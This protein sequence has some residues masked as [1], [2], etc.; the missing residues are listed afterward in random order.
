MGLGT[1][2]AGSSKVYLNMYNNELVLEYTSREDLERRLDSLGIEK[3]YYEERIQVRK[4]T[5]GKN[6]GQEV[7]YFIFDFVSGLIT[8]LVIEAPDWGGELLKVEITDVDQKIVINL[9]DVFGRVAKDFIRRME[10]IDL[11]SEVTFR[12]WHMTGDETNTGKS[13]SGVYILQE[14]KKIDYALSYQDMPQPVEKKKGRTKEWDYTEQEQFLY[15]TLE[16]FLKNNFN[17]GEVEEAP[18]EPKKPKQ[19]RNTRKKTAKVAEAE[20]EDDDAPF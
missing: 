7:F 8:D 16:T 6:E 19:K 3:D 1:R 9:G 4:K 17:S 18:E 14:D 2:G 12:V 5:K 20:G 11:G 13:R 15:E 10:N